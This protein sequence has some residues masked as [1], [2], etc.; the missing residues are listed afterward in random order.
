VSAVGVP[1]GRAAPAEA[2]MTEF[3]VEFPWHGKPWQATVDQNGE[4]RLRL[5]IGAKQDAPQTAG[6]LATWEDAE[7][8]RWIYTAAR[9]QVAAFKVRNGNAG[10]PAVTPSWR[11]SSLS[12]P[13]APVVANGIVYSLAKT[14]VDGPLVL[15]AVDALTGEELYTSK[16]AIKSRASSSNLAVANGHVCF[17]TTDSQTYCFGLPFEL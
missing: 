16:D 13:V 10:Q 11:L 3:P 6:R 17:S 7:A 12:D 2:G 8:T 9:S 4:P 15:R 14:A 5:A 1:A